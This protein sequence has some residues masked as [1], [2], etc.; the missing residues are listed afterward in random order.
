VR[1]QWLRLA[2]GGLALRLRGAAAA[3]GSVLWSLR[4]LGLFALFAPVSW[5]WAVTRR[6][7]DAAWAFCHR[8][9]RSLL[10][11]TGVPLAAHGLERLVAS[12]PV[13]AVCNHSSY[14]DGM[15]LVAA[16]PQR[17]AFVAKRELQQQWIAGRFLQSLGADFVE[18]FDPRRSV[19]DAQRMAQSASAGTPLLVFP[20]GTF[21][22][23]AGLRPFH[24]GAFLAAAQ[25]GVP[26]LPM[27]LT[28]TRRMLGDG[29]WWPRRGALALHVGPP[30]EAA[31][32]LEPFAAAVQLRDAAATS[33]ARRLAADDT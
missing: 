31:A 19:A 14:L 7:P 21:G 32:G 33:I 1:R 22:A 18:R 27:T 17:H 9:A 30:L 28:G 20:E 11:L 2:A 29:R 4:A 5:C 24:L 6:D 16:L 25:A 10:R 23:E 3:V 13:V 15:V 12:T 26:V 8:A